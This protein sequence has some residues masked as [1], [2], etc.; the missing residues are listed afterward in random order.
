MPRFNNDLRGQSTGKNRQARVS[1]VI[2][3]FLCHKQF[4]ENNVTK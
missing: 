4:I 1:F 2:F 3:F